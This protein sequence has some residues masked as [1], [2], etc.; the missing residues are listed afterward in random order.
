VIWSCSGLRCSST[1]HRGPGWAEHL[2]NTE[3]SP[4]GAWLRPNSEGKDLRNQIFLNVEFKTTLD[5]VYFLSF[6]PFGVL[7]SGH[8]AC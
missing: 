1:T 2:A 3:C 5:F 7:N 6:W 8:W 4:R